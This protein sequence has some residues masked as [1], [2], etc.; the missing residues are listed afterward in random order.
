MLRESTSNASMLVSWLRV[1]VTTCLFLQEFPVIVL[2]WIGC[3]LDLDEVIRGCV[4]LFARECWDPLSYRTL[5]LVV[6]PFLNLMVSISDG[7]TLVPILN[8]LIVS[9]L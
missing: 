7:Q 9:R 5:S 6:H 8:L 1:R 4:D 3:P 2:N